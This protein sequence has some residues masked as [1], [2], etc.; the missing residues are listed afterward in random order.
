MWKCRA[1]AEVIVAAIVLAGCSEPRAPVAEPSDP[2]DAGAY[3]ALRVKVDL[4]RGTRWQ[5]GWGAAYVYDVASESFIRR[6]PLSGAFF[7]GAR[8]TCLP[9][10]VLRRSGA[11]IVSSNAQPVLWRISPARYEVE[12]F[13][14]ALDSDKDRDFGFSGLAWDAQ[15][16]VLFAVSAVTG[17]LW[18]VDL[19]AATASKVALSSPIHGACGLT[20]AASRTESEPAVLVA[21]IRSDNTSR[22]IVLSPDSTRAEVTSAIIS[23]TPDAAREA[24]G[25]AR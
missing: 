1:A 20:L 3:Q 10:M 4:A 12:R 8:E 5:L 25:A 24:R 21:W 17:T 9:D 19:D 11:L 13:E 15:E 23:S 2:I 16:R 18:R 14:I 6:V 7:A 22:R